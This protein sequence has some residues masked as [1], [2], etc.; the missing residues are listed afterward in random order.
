MTVELTAVGGYNEVG[1]QCTAIKVDDDVF[2]VDLGLH[3]D[4]YI[5]YTEDEEEDITT[6][7]RRGLRKAGAIPDWTSIKDWKKDVRAIILTHAHLDHIGA[8]PYLAEIFDCPIYASPFTIALLKQLIEDK[9]I[10]LEN[11]LVKVTKPVQLTDAVKLELIHMTHSTVDCKMVVLHTPHGAVVVDND[12]KIDRHPTL[13]QPPDFES[14]KKLSGKV[15]AHVGECL[16]APHQTKT[17]SESVARKMLEEVLLEEN[18][19][20]RAV[21]V[22]TFSSHIARLSSIMDMGKALGREVVFLGRSMAKYLTAAE[23]A[24]ILSVPRHV[25]IL[26][27]GSQI[28]KFFKQQKD[29]SKFLIVCTGHM[30][31]PKAALSKLADGAYPF[32]FRPG[33]VVVF[34]SNVIPMPLIIANREELTRKLRSQQ[35]RIFDGVHVSGHA[36]KEDLR[37]LML[38]LGAKHLIPNHGSPEMTSAYVDIAREAG[39]KPERIHSL[40]EGDRIVLKP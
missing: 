20:G 15:L 3:L 5:K 1:R 2:I 29:L 17:P 8:V 36:S 31:E 33:D 30:G 32:K 4:Q 13:G 26:K 16:Y 9:N 23:E 35:V 18:F 27:Y 19:E 7:S 21:F 6:T 24:N 14:I 34:S 22:S 39:V 38:T 40:R 37:W 25:Q 11:R 10:S 12:F 28:R